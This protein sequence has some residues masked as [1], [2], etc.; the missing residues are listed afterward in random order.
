M[1]KLKAGHQQKRHS[2]GCRKDVL[3]LLILFHGAHKW[4]KG[5]TARIPHRDY[6]H[7][8]PHKS[9]NQHVF[10]RPQVSSEEATIKEQGVD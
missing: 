2:W 4:K 7:L 3:V 1:E 9:Y 6:D 8:S 5:R 10:I